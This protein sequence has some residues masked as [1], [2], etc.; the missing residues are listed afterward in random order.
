MKKF[1]AVLLSLVLVSTMSAIFVMAEDV[2]VEPI[3]DGFVF[4]IL[5]VDT[6]ITGEKG[7][8][9]TSA[10]ALA[11]SST[12]WTVLIHCEKVEDNLYKAKADAIVPDGNLKTLTFEENDIVIG[13]HSASSKPEDINSCPNQPQKVAA[14]KVKTGMY[15]TL[16]GI[17]LTAKTATDATATVNL[18]D[19]RATESD[20]SIVD[21]SIDESSIEVPDYTDI[22]GELVANPSYLLEVTAPATYVPGD[23]IN[24]TITLKNV[25]PAG[26]ISLIEF[27]LY[28]DSAKVEPVVLNNDDTLNA[29]MDAFLV[30]APTKEAWEVMCK[31]EEA[32]SRYNLSFL[33]SSATV[34][35]KED[36]SIVIVI[37]FKVKD[38][39]TGSIAFQAPH[40]DV[41]ACG[42]GSDLNSNYF[43]NA[44]LAIVTLATAE[45][46]S[47]DTSSVVEPGDAGMIAIALVAVLAL[48]GVTT[49]A[50]KKRSR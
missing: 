20:E 18:T 5:A 43:G 32:E 4:N 39:A 42:A 2:V 21:E 36:G 27:L 19:P 31:L 41:K 3:E 47:D 26:G 6:Q 34:N 44:G 16:E 37:P 24:V 12:G 15:I 23:T 9:L 46:S 10:E 7:L 50:V 35:A 33:T 28:Y 14:L 49:L 45:E 29:E 11:A 8:V 1:L 17:D 13:I 40:A 22:T 48:A 38:T 25:V 30:T